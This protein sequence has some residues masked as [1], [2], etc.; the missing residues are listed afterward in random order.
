MML[1]ESSTKLMDECFSTNATSPETVLRMMTLL[2]D[3]LSSDKAEIEL[4][5]TLDRNPKAESEFD[6]STLRT[7][8]TRP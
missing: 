5:S 3:C 4:T 1:E 2:H 8:L 7:K 6:S